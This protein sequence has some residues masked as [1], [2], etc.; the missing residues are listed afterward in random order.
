VNSLSTLARGMRASLCR[1]SLT[2]AA[3]LAGCQDA[4]PPV[5]P[6]AEI[7]PAAPIAG[8]QGRIVFASSGNKSLPDLNI[9]DLATGRTQRLTRDRWWDADPAWSPN[10]QKIAFA[11]SRGDG[12]HV[13]V[14]SATGGAVTR[15]SHTSTPN[16]QP[17]W[18]PDGTLILY[19]TQGGGNGDIVLAN[20]DGSGTLAV[21][22]AHPAE[23]FDPAWSPTSSSGV[24]F[25]FTSR[26]DNPIGDIYIYDDSKTPNVSRLTVTASGAQQPAWSPDGTKIAYVVWHLGAWDVFVTNADGTGTPTNLTNN[27]AHDQMPA[28]SPD[29]SKIVF[30]SNRAGNPDLYSMNADGTGVTRLTRGGNEDGTPSWTR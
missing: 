11:S 6:Q 8:L 20:A 10:G 18:S 5:A 26:R 19:M 15:V 3:L 23:D 4:P 25:A 28:W 9:L 30:A 29:G 1:T 21:L 7:V 27:W 13:Y 16:I 14:M 24:K 22:A 2:L 12:Q 17:S